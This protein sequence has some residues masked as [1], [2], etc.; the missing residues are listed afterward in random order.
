MCIGFIINP[1]Q[2]Y[3]GVGTYYRNLFQN[4]VLLN[5][6]ITIIVFLPKDV[7]KEAFDFFKDVECVSMPVP[8]TPSWKRALYTY[9]YRNIDSW[10]HGKKIDVLHS[11]SFP[12]FFCSGKNVL[13]VYDMRTEDMPAINTPLRN[14]YSGFFKKNVLKKMDG[15]IAISDF[16][17]NQLAKH[18]PI[19]KSKS[20]TIYLGGGDRFN[21]IVGEKPLDSTY[22]LSVGHLMPRKNLSVLI[23]AYDLLVKE[24]S[25]THN[26]LIIGKYFEKDL[27][28]DV[29]MKN[30]PNKDRIII[31]S[32]LTEKQ[33]AGAYANAELF[34]FPSLYEGFG[35]PLL[36]AGSFSI[37][38]LASTSSVFPEMLKGHE[39]LLFESNNYKELAIKMASTLF[40]AEIKASNINIVS[41]LSKV[42][43]WNTMSKN[44]LLFYKDCLKEFK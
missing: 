34:V 6:E 32:N 19:T 12:G 20:R 35:I 29:A 8:S 44:T 43:N 25:C 27:E 37:P 40:N 10:W 33:L 39:D 41:K 7:D 9:K 21:N 30:T 28:F 11:F 22:I 26:L 16:T 36:E 17:R 15:I 24:R 31:M 5:S 13:T 23:K 4:L 14:L 38:C 18:Y 42:M 3:S 1:Y 2:K